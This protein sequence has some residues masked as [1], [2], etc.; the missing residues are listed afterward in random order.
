VT[1]DDQVVLG[2]GAGA[3]DRRTAGQWTTA[4]SADVA[5]VYNPGRPVTQLWDDYAKYLYLPRLRDSRRR[6]IPLASR[7]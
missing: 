5:G 7:N 2:T 4:K 6:T 3:V 1:V